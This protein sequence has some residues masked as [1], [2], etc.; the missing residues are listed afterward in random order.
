MVTWRSLLA[1]TAPHDE[2]REQIQDRRQIE[3]AAAADDELRRV[4]DPPLIRRGRREVAIEQIGCD[5]LIV[6][7]HR[8][9]L[10]ALAEPRLQARFLHQAH[11]PFAADML[12]LLEEILVDA[13]TPVALV[14][15]GEGR[16][17]QHSQSTVVARM[18]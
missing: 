17:H 13:R 6:I 9:H 14:A 2:P 10:V 11:D 18:R 4:A 1:L 7:A 8:R 16:P 3:L 12:V 5:R 15:L